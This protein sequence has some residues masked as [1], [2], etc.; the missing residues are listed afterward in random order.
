MNSTD[1]ADRITAALENAHGALG[2]LDSATQTGAPVN[3]ANVN[4]L[5]K[6]VQDLGEIA[7][8]ARKAAMDDAAKA[9][10]GTSDQDTAANPADTRT[11]RSST[12]GGSTP[13]KP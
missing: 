5:R 12:P 3:Q 7:N 1:F 13:S 8:D 10:T 2:E 4:T 6:V 9:G 11:P